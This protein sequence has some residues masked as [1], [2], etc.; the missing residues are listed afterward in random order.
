MWA[1]YN[2]FKGWALY[3]LNER[4]VQLL[5]N[6]LAK[7]EFK[8]ISICHL[9]EKKWEP[10][11]QLKQPQFF[12]ETGKNKNHFPEPIINSVSSES[13][14]DAEYFIVKPKKVILPRLHE[15]I[16]IE[17]DVTIEGYHQKFVSK[18]VDLS[19]GGIYFKETIP[20]WVSGYFIVLVNHRGQSHQIMCSLVEDQK[21]KHRVQVMSE[22]TDSHYVSYKIF[23]DQLRALI[24]HKK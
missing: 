6:S 11:D 3:G 24:K 9:T 21:I 2:S 19:E 5:V 14:S 7:N 4:E 17:I 13:V 23:L 10:L 15:R 16:D 1:I 20:D 12:S 8:F 18:T 22:E